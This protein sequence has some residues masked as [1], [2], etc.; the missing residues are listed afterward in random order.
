MRDLNA[1][2]YFKHGFKASDPDY[3]F[4]RKGQIGNWQEHLSKE[5]SDKLDEY[6]QKNLKYKG[7][8]IYSVGNK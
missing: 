1:F 5:A 4:F 8:F 7:K 3:T 2:S 6:V